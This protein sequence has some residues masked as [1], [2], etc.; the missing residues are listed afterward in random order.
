MMFYGGLDAAII[1][2]GGGDPH[3]PILRIKYVKEKNGDVRIKTK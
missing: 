1:P 2:I 3:K